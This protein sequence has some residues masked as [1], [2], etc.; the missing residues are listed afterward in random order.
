MFLLYFEQDCPAATLSGVRPN[1]LYRATW[2][3]PRAGQWRDAALPE[4]GRI[5]PP[6]LVG[7][8][9][10]ATVLVNLPRAPAL[11]ALGVFVA[12]YGGWQLLGARRMTK[13]SA[14]W[15]LPI[16]I[17]G[18]TFSVLFGQDYGLVNPLFAESLAWVADPLFW[19]AGNLWRRT[20]QIS[21]T[22]AGKFGDIGLTLQAAALSP[23]DS[24][25]DVANPSATPPVPEGP[26]GTDFGPG[27][28]TDSGY[29]RLVKLWKRGT[30]LA[31]AVTV[32]EGEQS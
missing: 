12:G 28:L 31:S 27:T 15:A 24:Y 11:A 3:D 9:L 1:S 16:G 13:A 25:T 26:H 30:P 20:P 7:I 17:A 6:A 32:F 29:P 14:W 5:L 19:Q 23:A 22:Y 4:I 21:A 2:F 10:G 18:G 8:A